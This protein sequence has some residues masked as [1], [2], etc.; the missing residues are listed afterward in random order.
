[1]PVSPSNPLPSKTNNQ[2]HIHKPNQKQPSGGPEVRITYGDG[3]IVGNAGAAT[4][5]L[6]GTRGDGSDGTPASVSFSQPLVLATSVN[7]GGGGDG[8]SSSSSGGGSGKDTAPWDGLLGMGREA[9]SVRWMRP[10][11]LSIAD[12]HNGSGSGA[13]GGARMFGLYLAHDASAAGQG[14]ELALG[15][16]NTA[17]TQGPVHW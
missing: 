11:L 5:T 7:I 14:G 15:G 13:G 8:S 3:Q 6:R 9:L 1:V 2:Q 12:Q 4:V 17:L 16:W 10:P